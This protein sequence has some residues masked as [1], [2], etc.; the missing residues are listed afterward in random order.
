[1][2]LV[3][4]HND[5]PLVD[6]LAPPLTTIRIALHEMGVQAAQLLLDHIHGTHSGAGRIVLPPELVVRGST[7]AP[8][9]DAGGRIKRP[10][11]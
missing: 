11:R 8:R 7:A 6:M 4:G 1:M 3:V 2:A 10:R 5:M 9:K